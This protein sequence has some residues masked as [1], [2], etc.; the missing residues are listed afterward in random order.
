MSSVC[1]KYFCSISV[2]Q[3]NGPGFLAPRTFP[4]IGVSRILE[5]E[6]SVGTFATFGRDTRCGRRSAGSAGIG[7]QA[8]VTARGIRN[9]RG[10]SART[11]GRRVAWGYPQLAGPSRMTTNSGELAPEPEGIRSWR[12]PRALMTHIPGRIFVP[13]YQPGVSAFGGALAPGLWRIIY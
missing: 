13:L 4:W 10:P 11:A 1:L 8:A 2:G 7:G 3:W 9:R 5:W 12:G 6:P